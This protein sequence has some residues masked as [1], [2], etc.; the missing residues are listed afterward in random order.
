M[1]AIVDYGV[2]NLASVKKAFDL[3]GAESAVTADPAVVRAASHVVLPGVGH[4]SATRALDELKLRPAIRSAIE[5]GVPFL[6]ICVGMQW[7]FAGSSEAPGVA[8][9]GLLAGV[10]ERFPPSV[11][12]PHVGWN[13]IHAREGSGSRLLRGVAPQAFVYYT[14][15]YRGPVGPECVAWSQYGGDFAA[16]LE[17][18]NSFGVQFHPEKSGPAGLQILRNFCAAGD[19]R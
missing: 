2:G 7:M 5:Q 18:G 12:C 9:L 1:I 10:C 14:H 13:R 4:F 11:K 3:L 8:G 16:V 19:V 6:G 15:S 17:I